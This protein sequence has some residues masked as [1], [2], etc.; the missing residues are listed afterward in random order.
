MLWSDQRAD[1]IINAMSV[2]VEDYFHVTAFDKTVP[3]GTW[4]RLES[5][6]CR[7][8]DALLEMFAD[9]GVRGTFFVLGWVAERYPRLIRTIAHAG[10]EVACHSHQH[11][12]VFDMTR[13]EFRNDLRRAKR[14]IEDA[15]G[16]SVIGYRAPTFSIT[17]Q[18]LWALDVL[19][20]EGFIY[21]SSIF[22]IHHDRY[23]IP[24][25]SRHV[26]RI[27]RP[28]GSI[29][30]VP[31]STL[32]VAGVNVPV[33][34]GGYFRILPYTWSRWAISRVNASEGEP[35]IFYL[36]P[37][38]ID[39]G[40]PRMPAALAARW[41]HEFGLS[42]TRQRLQ[43]LVRAFRFA[44]I[45]DVLA[46]RIHIGDVYGHELASQSSFA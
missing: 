30:E 9:G 3:R 36:H 31:A 39:P 24:E 41:R 11:R 13:D 17:K 8:T 1:R 10:H 25:A 28:A 32:R 38:E 6:V 20:E 46:G 23:G 22:P 42:R 15:S 14:A 16:A 4:D 27:T 26:H 12:L 34:G 21:D 18:S 29:W 33:G 35:V 40:Q 5:R 2:D 45:R 43:R 7:N 44:P 19:I 37:W